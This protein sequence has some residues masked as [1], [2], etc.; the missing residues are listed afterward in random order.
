LLLLA[1]AAARAEEPGTDGAPPAAGK[2]EEAK[3]VVS[4]RFPG[5]RRYTDEYLRERIASKVG[6]RFD[7]GLLARDEEIL[8]EYFAEVTEVEDLV[9]EKGVEIVFHVEDRA[10]AGNVEVKGASHVDKADW[11][12]LLL[13]RTG[14]PLL[15]YALR[16]DEQTIAR[17]HRE[18]GHASAEVQAYRVRTARADVDDVAFYVFAGPRVKVDE[19]LLEGA[20]SLKRSLI[21]RG[22]KNSDRYK[23]QFLGLARLFGPSWFDRAALEEDRRRIELIYHREGFLDA[24]VTLVDVRLNAKRDRATIVY[25][26]E[27]GARYRL[28]RFQ[29]RYASAPAGAPQPE[30]AG[31]LSPEA[32]AGLCTIAPGEPWRDEDVER[33]RRDILDRVWSRAYAVADLE[34]AATPNRERRVVDAMV[35][36]RAGTKVKLGRVRVAGNY[37]TKD[38]V[39]RRE[40]RDGALP[41]DFL[42]LQALEEARNR[43][44]AKQYFSRVRY[45]E[46]FSPRDGLRKSPDASAP[47]EYDI[48]LD[49]AEEEDVRRLVFGAG[50]STDGGLF[51][52]IEVSWRNF[53]IAKPPNRP[54]G[55][56]DREAFRGAGQTFTVELAPGTVFSTGRVSF[57]D[58][59]VGDSPWGFQVSVARQL[60]LLEDYRQTVDSFDIGFSRYLDRRYRWNVGA[61]A[62]LKQVLLDDLDAPAPVNAI[63]AQGYTT[64][65]GVRAFLR[66]EDLI[67]DRFLRGHTTRLEGVVYSRLAGSDVDLVKVQFTHRIGNRIFRQDSGGWHHWQLSFDLDWV[68]AYGSTT[69]VPI[70][71]RYFVGGRNL[72]GFEFREVGPRSNDRPTGGDFSLLLSLLYTIPIA[73][74]EDAGFGIDLVFFLDQGSLSEDLG[75]FSVDDWR[76]SVGFGIAISIG[77]PSQPPLEID[78]GFPILDREGDRTQ[79]ISISFLR[80]F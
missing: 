62:L 45:G 35:T 43:L 9:T 3:K 63:D 5:N 23:S 65:N 12:P 44:L 67:A 48:E 30:D 50:V 47:D 32:L 49:L 18:K 79:L 78:F 22:A 42:D 52:Q 6:Q 57:S 46:G 60:S 54:F 77:G 34:I 15:E 16:A 20:S 10:L 19:V 64:A 31:F 70:F 55:I 41:G 4:V 8:R 33:T 72:R 1:A 39:I 51:G 76:A 61:A 75:S 26:V 36:I 74:Q 58:P 68:G 2:P 59:A 71:E 28:G 53:D 17:L 25:R 29:V 66:Y 27:E 69:S 80:N 37:Y 11:E 7:P 13:T 38:N 40:F 56:L 14:R 24:R 21:L 73:Y